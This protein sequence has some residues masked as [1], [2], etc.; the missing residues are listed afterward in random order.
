MVC[1]H[2]MIALKDIQ[3]ETDML[4]KVNIFFEQQNEKLNSLNDTFK[5]EVLASFREGETQ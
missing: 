5:Q 3:V 1:D 2:P 4:N